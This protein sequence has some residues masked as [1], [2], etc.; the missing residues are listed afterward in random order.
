V[1]R[2]ISFVYLFFAVSLFGVYDLKFQ[3][4]SGRYHTVVLNIDRVAYGFGSNFMGQLGDRSGDDKKTPTK[5]AF[6]GKM[7][8]LNA[9]ENHT[10]AIDEN[11]QVYAWGD[12]KFGQLGLESIESFYTPQKVDFNESVIMLSTAK[13]HTLFL[14][15]SQK[16]YG[17]GDN[18]L[19]QLG[20]D[21][22]T[23]RLKPKKI[24]FFD[25]KDIV[26]VEAGDSISFAITRSGEVYSFGSNCC[27]RLGL[28]MPE[29]KINHI[30]TPQKIDFYGKKIVSISAGSSHALAI[31]EEGRVYSWGDNSYGQLGIASEETNKNIPTLLDYDFVAT[32]VKAKGYFS[33]LLTKDELLYS[34]GDNSS[35]QLG[36]GYV[37]TKSY[38][39]LIN[40]KNIVAIEAGLNSSFA[41]DRNG[42][43]YCFGK[44]SKGE[45]G[46]G[47]T[48]SSKLPVK[49]SFDRSYHINYEQ[50]YAKD[51][52]I[53][54]GWNLIGA[55]F[56]LPFLQ[57]NI[58]NIY[59]YD[60]GRWVEYTLFDDT[61]KSTESSIT[62][63]YTPKGT[64]IN[65][66]I[67]TTMRVVDAKTNQPFLYEN[68]WELAGSDIE[69]EAK[70]IGC[71]YSNNITIYKYKP[72]YGWLVYKEG[73]AYDFDKINAFEGFWV[74][75]Y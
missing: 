20:D 55:T 40:L 69:V 7:E 74:N 34:F 1:F 61:S 3:I 17:C 14:T 26:F 10:L 22:T 73:A 45:F 52:D 13:N 75:C 23:T 38:P 25:D 57:K 42:E 12:N 16:V 11:N 48:E 66:S 4:A 21:N 71:K 2:K 19:G 43:L 56:D 5:V 59:Q 33:L 27:G 46:N 54:S 65:S 29:S 44:N 36:I 24:D 63:L 32:M 39:S 68:G 49:S 51:I 15:Q 64:W 62:R 31:N 6:N 47:G 9:A 50:S 35:G 8:F 30:S 41:L 37:L 18:R 67:N 60:N 70:N 72:G 53:Y 58:L 28:G